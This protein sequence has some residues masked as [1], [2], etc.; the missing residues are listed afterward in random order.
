MFRL[1]FFA[2]S[3]IKPS[4]SVSRMDLILY[5][6]G[7]GPKVRVDWNGVGYVKEVV[8]RRYCC[9]PFAIAETPEGNTVLIFYCE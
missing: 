7:L 2:S 4:L 5:W 6:L 1:R 8:R 3:V 9:I